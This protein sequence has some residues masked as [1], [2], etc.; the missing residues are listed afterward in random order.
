MDWDAKRESFESHR[1]RSGALR[2]PPVF[3]RGH[4]YEGKSRGLHVVEFKRTEAD[5]RPA[6]KSVTRKLMGDPAP[7][8]TPWAQE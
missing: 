1:Q 3:D 2:D 6:A 7:G 8:R 5:R 4:G